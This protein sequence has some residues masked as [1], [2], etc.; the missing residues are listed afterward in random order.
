MNYRNQLKVYHSDHRGLRSVEL[1]R[2]VTPEGEPL[3]PNIDLEGKVDNLKLRG[4]PNKGQHQ[5][6]NYDEKVLL[7]AWHPSNNTIAVAGKSGLCLYK[8]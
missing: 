3:S 5:D 7:T 4:N 1:P 8:A 6:L 2:V